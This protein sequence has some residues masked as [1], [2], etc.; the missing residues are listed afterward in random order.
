MEDQEKDATKRR[1]EAPRPRAR[2]IAAALTFTD[3]EVREI[4]QVFQNRAGDAQRTANIALIFT[5]F[6]AFAILSLFLVSTQLFPTNGGDSDLSSAA[7]AKLLWDSRVS[8]AA[9]APNAGSDTTLTDIKP[10]DTVRDVQLRIDEANRLISRLRQAQLQTELISQA[11]RS[12]GGILIRIGAVLIGIFIIQVMVNFV[13][14]N[15]RMYFHWAM[16]SALIRLSRGNHLIIN[17]VAKTLSPSSI[18]FGKDPKAPSEK[19][20]DA[21]KEFA[22]KIPDR[23]RG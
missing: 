2:R 16:C 4:A 19:L 8:E 11:V 22:K 7:A 20:I 6:V 10:T 17:S 5:I 3:K 15:S 23:G 21:F 1:H 12:I 18:D 9:S 14:Y 13:R